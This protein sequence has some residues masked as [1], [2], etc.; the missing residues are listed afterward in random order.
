MVDVT[1]ADCLLLGLIDR[2]ISYDSDQ[3]LFEQD[4]YL[5]GNKRLSAILFE[6]IAATLPQEK[7]E[8]YLK[9]RKNKISLL[10]W[11]IRNSNRLMEML[12][13]KQLE[14]LYPWVERVKNARSSKQREQCGGETLQLKNIEE[15]PSMDDR[16]QRMQ[17]HFQELCEEMKELVQDTEV[18]H[19]LSHMDEN[20]AKR[21]KC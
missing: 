4:C 7:Q 16:I 15:I 5:A 18:V 19:V 1:H 10:D 3:G 13:E 21:R 9:D 6:K 2:L 12:K 8:L 20:V 11:H 17:R 14:R